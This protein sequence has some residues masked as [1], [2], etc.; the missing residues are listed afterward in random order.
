MWVNGGYGTFDEEKLRKL[1][2]AGVRLLK[3]DGGDSSCDITAL[4]RKVAPDLTVEHGVCGT[5][6]PLNTGAENGTRWS[7]ADAKNQAAVLQCTDLLR[8]YDM[9]KVLSISECLDRQAQLILQARRLE[10]KGGAKRLF[11]G[12]GEPSVTAALGGAIQPMRS[13]MRGLPPLPDAFKAFPGESE[14]GRQR[15]HREDEIERLA[16]WARIAEPFGVGISSLGISSLTG[17]QE[18]VKVDSRGLYDS[19][20][21]A[22]ADDPSVISHK[23]ENK[24][25]RQGAPARVTRG[26]LP[27]PSVVAPEGKSLPFVVS[28]RFPTGPVSIT[29]LGRTDPGQFEE[30][31]VHVTQVIPRVST[32]SPSLVGIFGH[33]DALTLDFVADAAPCESGTVYDSEDEGNTDLTTK[34]VTTESGAACSERCDQTKGCACFSWMGPTAAEEK[35]GSAEPGCDAPTVGSCVQQPS[36][37]QVLP[38]VKSADECCE[39]CFG[40]EECGWW[41][42]RTNTTL[43]PGCHLKHAGT[44]VWRKDPLCTSGVG[45]AAP[46]SPPPP[47]PPTPPSV[48]GACRLMSECATPH[49]R[50]STSLES[51]GAQRQ[52]AQALTPE[53]GC[54]RRTWPAKWPWTSRPA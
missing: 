12:S 46:P 48:V 47:P 39:A 17:K 25:V 21:F 6:C 43:N 29:T 1:H 9:V 32:F 33:F 51:P 26:G 35:V 4:A 37:F 16:R 7:A 11:G 36:S 52:R 8:T 3:W 13:N 20:T 30:P 10:A 45:S 14:G 40:H 53:T 28:T 23:L 44:P 2:N 41:V 38:D 49:R 15:Q 18:R 24:T 19:W 34:I 42:H 50:R 54:W 27:L 22:L 31:K 5:G